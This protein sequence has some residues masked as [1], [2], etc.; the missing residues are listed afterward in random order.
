M[1]GNRLDLTGTKILTTIEVRSKRVDI[2]SGTSNVIFAGPCL[3]RGVNI[4][5]GFN[6]YAVTFANRTGLGDETIP[7]ASFAGTWI[8]Y[9]DS[10]F[11]DGLTA[12]YNASAT[13]DFTVKFI[14]LG[15]QPVGGV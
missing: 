4:H 7:A 15:A 11:P 13:G 1:T 9:G 2:S 3:L 5:T 12:T 10:F 8:P 14:P 6:A